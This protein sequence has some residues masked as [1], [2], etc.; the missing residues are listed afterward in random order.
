MEARIELEFDE[1]FKKAISEAVNNAIKPL[2]NEIILLREKV[3][4]AASDEYTWD[5]AQVAKYLKKGKSTVNYYR[6]KFKDFP[7][8]VF[9]NHKNVWNKAEIIAWAE[10]HKDEL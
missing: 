1:K 5:R 4:A 7:K 9:N 10:K 2:V 3:I 8:P 6:E